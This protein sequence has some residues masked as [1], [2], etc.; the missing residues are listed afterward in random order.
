MILDRSLPRVA[1]DNLIKLTNEMKI[2]VIVLQTIRMDARL[3]LKENL[4]NA[5]LRYPFKSTQLLEM[6]NE[7]LYKQQ[8]GQVVS[9][10]DVKLD[11][12]AFLLEG[13]LRVTNEEINILNYLEGV[14]KNRQNN[15]D[16]MTEGNAER[17]GRVDEKHEDSA[18][19]AE[20]ESFELPV[21]HGLYYVNAL[22]QK[23]EKLQKGLRIQYEINKG[24]GLVNAYE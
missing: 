24:Y 5:Y 9:I 8:S 4:A 12:G 3:L 10:G 15:R 22:N 21:R 14:Y 20:G 1:H 16:E 2:P 17:I 13:R 18:E 23:L 11:Q 6:M 7:I 19:K